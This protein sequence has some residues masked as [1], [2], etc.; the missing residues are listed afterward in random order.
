MGLVVVHVD[1]LAKPASRRNRAM[2]TLLPTLA[3]R[4]VNQVVGESRGRRDD[5]KDRAV[6]DGLRRSRRFPQGAASLYMNHMPGVEEPG[7]W[8]ADAICG[9]EVRR[10]LGESIYSETLGDRL[11]VI[12][13]S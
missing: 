2:A 12:S 13:T 4:G 8:V 11:E 1:A 6:L 9:A 7:L 5:E 10:R 3:T